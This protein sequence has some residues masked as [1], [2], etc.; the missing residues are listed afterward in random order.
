MGRLV[1]GGSGVYENSILFNQFCCETKFALGNKFSLEIAGRGKDT[2][3][4]E[5]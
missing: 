3:G 1:C 5:D 2:L 4:I